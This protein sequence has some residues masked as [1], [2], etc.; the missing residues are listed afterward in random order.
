M[1]HSLYYDH[2]NTPIGELTLVQSNNGLCL[3]EFGPLEKTELQIKAW[4]KRWGF[5]QLLPDAVALKEVKLQLAEYFSKERTSFELQLDLRGTP[6][7]Q[8]VWSALQ[9]IPYGKT[10][11]YKAVAEYINQPKAVRAI[12]M[13]NHRNP[14]PLVVPCHRVIGSNGHLVGY[15]GGLEIKETLLNIEGYCAENKNKQQIS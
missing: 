6:F 15:G 7:Q 12:G 13:A 3:I 5:T 9:C 14:V 11:S 8:Q 10:W 2:M 1:T 4:M